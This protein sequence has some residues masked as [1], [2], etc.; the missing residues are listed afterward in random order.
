MTQLD[1]P[2]VNSPPTPDAWGM[3]DMRLYTLLEEGAGGVEDW[4][5]E[6]LPAQPAQHVG[7]SGE[8][9]NAKHEM[10]MRSRLLRLCD[11]A[12]GAR[13][14]LGPVY[15]SFSA[16]CDCECSCSREKWDVVVSRHAGIGVHHRSRHRRQDAPEA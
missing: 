13:S 7:C 12:R 1:T 5:E 10:A 14:A 8:F 16:L 3:P 11:F 15:F 4:D 2:A 9:V 6:S